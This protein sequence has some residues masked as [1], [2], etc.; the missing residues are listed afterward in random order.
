MVTA[1][2]HHFYGIAPLPWKLFHD[3]PV[4]LRWFLSRPPK[5]FLDERVFPNLAHAPANATIFMTSVSRCAQQ[6]Q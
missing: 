1:V 2:L 4:R 5:T 6:G 3:F